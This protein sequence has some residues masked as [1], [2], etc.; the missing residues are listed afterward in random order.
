MHP[1][2]A[3]LLAF[4]SLA[5]GWLPSGKV[6]GVNLGS[7]FIIE[8]WMAQQEWSSMGCGGTNDEWGCV[9]RLG[10]NAADAAFQKHWGSW[11]TKGDLS[12]MSS[13]GLNTIR[14]PVGYWIKEDLVDRNSEQFPRG[15]LA[16]LDNIVGWAADLNMYVI[17][18]LHAAPGSQAANQQFTGHVS[19]IP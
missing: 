8:P 6:R 19:V 18:D 10:Q 1:R 12:T 16:Y 7:L 4:A 14:I 15:G 13:W 2:F 9:Q 17:M 5:W 3:W 11:I